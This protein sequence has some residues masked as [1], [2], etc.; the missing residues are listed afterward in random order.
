MKSCLMFFAVSL[1]GDARA[2]TIAFTPRSMLLTR[3]RIELP[4]DRMLRAL[5]RISLAERSIVLT[6]SPIE[7]TLVLIELALPKL[8][9]DSYGMS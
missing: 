4:L 5:D 3:L 2:A 9:E 7:L 6:L 1:I 8:R